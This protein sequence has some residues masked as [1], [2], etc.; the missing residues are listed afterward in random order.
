MKNLKVRNLF[1]MASVLVLSGIC[2][3][4]YSQKKSDGATVKEGVKLEYKYQAG[5]SFKYL[6]DTKIVQ[7]LDANGQS[8]Q[9]NISTILAC[10]A[11]GSG[12]VGENL[13]LEIKID[14][15]TNAVE[16][17]Q[18]NMGGPV[19]EL[20]GKTFNMI[21]TPG[22]K[23][24]DLS[25]AATVVYNTGNGQRDMAESFR[26]F[27]PS[28]PSGAVKPGDTWIV[29]DTVNIKRQSDT[30]YMPQ[31]LSYKFDGFEN[32]EGIE[33]AKVSAEIS[34][35][36]KMSTQS[37]G[38]TINIKGPFTGTLEMLI[39]VKDGYL[40]K[41]TITTKMTGTLEMPDQGGM[42]FPDVMTVTSTTSL[43]K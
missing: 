24:A 25:E 32:V 21:L 16:S 12:K 31:K 1:R 43:V 39:A 8:M 41:E 28:L 6:S 4:L 14:S 3:A 37:G 11:K 15:M 7:D 2:S 5:K 23:A 22:G 10:Q 19:A 36:R 17:P 29:N 26:N 9:V 13:K 33:C 40:V 18:G 20:K 30:T 27:F 42:S 34:G 38:M 35:D